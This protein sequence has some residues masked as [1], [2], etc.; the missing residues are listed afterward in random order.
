[1][2]S[3]ESQNTVRMPWPES[4]CSQIT[5]IC[6]H[7]ITLQFLREQ[8]N[9]TSSSSSVLQFLAL[10]YLQELLLLKL[11]VSKYAF[12]MCT[13]NMDMIFNYAKYF[14]RLDLGHLK[15]HSSWKTYLDLGTFGMVLWLMAGTKRQR[16]VLVCLCLDWQDWHLLWSVE[17]LCFRRIGWIFHLTKS[18]NWACLLACYLLRIMIWHTILPGV[19]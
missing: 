18:E 10:V 9:N 5:E 8:Q 6:M 15:D 17:Y 7:Y 19:P 1:M 12:L 3:Y 4:T 14:C 16:S 13:R 11:H 2:T